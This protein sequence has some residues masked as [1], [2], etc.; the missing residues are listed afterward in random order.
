MGLT[1]VITA[2]V[3]L[4]VGLLTGVLVAVAGLIVAPEMQAMATLAGRAYWLLALLL[5][6]GLWLGIWIT[7]DDTEHAAAYA[8]WGRAVAV[9]CASAVVG[10]GLG[11]GPFYLLALT[12][13]PVIVHGYDV[14]V[15]APLLRSQILWAPWLAVVGVTLLVALPLAAWAYRAGRGTR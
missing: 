13:L 4:G 2:S 3:P 6:L 7:H 10:G 9:A 1:L 5:P 11:A 14:G 12:Y 8:S 15:W